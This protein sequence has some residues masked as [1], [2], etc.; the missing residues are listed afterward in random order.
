VL[1]KSLRLQAGELAHQ[2]LNPGLRP[3]LRTRGRESHGHVVFRNRTSSGGK[4]SGYR[5]KVRE[6]SGRTHKK[7]KNEILSFNQ[8]RTGKHNSVAVDGKIG[9]RKGVAAGRSGRRPTEPPGR[10]CKYVTV[11]YVVGEFARRHTSGWPVSPCDARKT[12]ATQ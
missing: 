9:I 2:F 6:V 5:T 3:V 4:D 1:E 11:E 12:K 7:K 10:R 8:C